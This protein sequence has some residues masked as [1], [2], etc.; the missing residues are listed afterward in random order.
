MVAG[1]PP[2]VG[3]VGGGLEYAIAPRFTVKV[4][5]LYDFINA[6]PVVFN[7]VAG[8]SIQFN[9]RTDYHIG[10]VGLNYKFDWLS[11]LAAPVVAKY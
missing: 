10:R 4:E 11:P 1:V 3:A 5:Y 6:R 9:T 8:S 2:H 7:P